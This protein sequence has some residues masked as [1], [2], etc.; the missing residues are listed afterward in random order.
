[1]PDHSLYLPILAQ[2]PSVLDVPFAA[3][4]LLDAEQQWDTLNIHRSKVVPISRCSSSV[5]D[6]D[7]VERVAPKQLA[8]V[9]RP[10]LAGEVP[11]AAGLV[12]RIAPRHALTMYAHGPLAAGSVL[13]CCCSLAILSV[14]LGYAIQGSFNPPATPTVP[15]PEPQ[16]TTPTFA[17][18]SVAVSINH[19]TPSSVN[20]TTSGRSSLKD[21]ALAVLPAPL[22][23]STSASPPSAMP[24]THRADSV[25]TVDA[26]SECGCGCGL[27]TWPGKSDKGTTDLVLRATSSASSIHDAGKSGLALLPSPQYTG[28]GKAVARGNNAAYALGSW[29]GGGVLAELLGIGYSTVAHDVQE[30]MDALDELARVIARQTALVWAQSAGAVN[31]LKARLQARHERARTRALE[32]RQMGGKLFE[33]VQERVRARVGRARENARAA[34]EEVLA[35][36]AWPVNGRQVVEAVTARRLAR[37]R[38]AYRKA[39]SAFSQ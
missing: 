14:V 9:L 33:S 20:P 25:A 22:V 30:I 12:Q 36:D 32:L 6:V 18:P 29:I 19:S 31:G 21:F 2:C 8:R 17:F 38:R 16:Q 4:Q 23:A 26:P 34:K 28:K 27:I 35:V 11:R 37:E 10:V 5:V 39:R 7:E 24:S 15:T 13:M 3:D 1:M